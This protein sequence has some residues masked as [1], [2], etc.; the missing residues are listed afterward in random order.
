MPMAILLFLVG[1][2][3]GIAL[4]GLADNLPPDVLG[5]RRAPGRPRCRYCGAAHRPE[6]WLALAGLLARGGRCEH[7]GGPRPLRH[8]VV[9]AAAG[10]SL[11]YLWSWAEGQAFK[12]LAAAV[13]VALFILITVIDLEHRLI[14]W[15]VIYPAAVI[16]ALIGVLSPDRGWQKTLVGGAVGFGLVCGM[17]LLGEVFSRVIHL[18]RG[19]PLD[20]VAFG[21]GDVNLAAVIGLAVGWSGVL[22]AVLIAI[23][24]AAAFG[25]VYLVVQRL[26]GRYTLFTAIPYGPFLVLGALTIYL[27]GQEIAAAYAGR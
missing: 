18:A 7:C 19:Q 20:E 16:V 12:F 27:Y 23:F 3:M 14:L 1:L 15:V 24:S 17:F 25:L 9:E 4:N 8:V 2:G 21:W 5:M 11:A 26:R 22:F 10:F 6:Y 13:I